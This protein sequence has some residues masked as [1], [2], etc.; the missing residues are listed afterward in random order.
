M[1][2][3]YGRRMAVRPNGILGTAM[4]NRTVLIVAY[5]VLA[6]L[7]A[8]LAGFALFGGLSDPLKAAVGSAMLFVVYL[9]L[10]VSRKLGWIK[11]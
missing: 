10:K 11:Q 2:A 3:R 9:G 8:A 1:A 6:V 7:A 5:G 4:N